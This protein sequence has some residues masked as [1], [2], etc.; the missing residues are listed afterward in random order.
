M[1]EQVLV[2]EREP[3]TRLT[4]GSRGAVAGLALGLVALGLLF[5]TEIAVAVFIWFDSTAYNHCFLV[6]PIAAWLVWERRMTLRHMTPMPIPLVALLALPLGAVWLVAERLGIMEGR[7]LVAVTMAEVLFLAILGRR[8]FLA[9][10]GPLLYLYFLVPFGEFLTPQLQ[11]VTT[12][13]T[14][15]G[16]HLL[17]I[18]AYIDGY[19]IEIPEGVF[20]VAEACAG[21]RFLIASVA[22][23]VLYSIMMYRSPVRRVVFI[24]ASIVIPVIANGIRALGIVVLGHILG[25]AEA[26]ATDHILYGWIFFSIV[27]LLLTLVGLPFRE[28]NRPEPE[29]GPPMIPEPD[30]PRRSVYAGIAVVAAA[31]VGPLVVL[32]L[33]EAAAVPASPRPLDL[34]PSCVMMGA[35]VPLKS[36]PMGHAI[37][38]RMNCGGNVMAVQVEVFSPRST[39]APINAERRRLT[40]P[41]DSEDMTDNALPAEGGEGLEA[42]R[43]LRTA[44]P[45][46]VSAVG[47]W[48]NGA[49]ARPGLAMRLKMAETSLTGTSLAPVIVTVTPVVDWSRVNPKDL[50][51]LEYRLADWLRGHRMIGD[52]VRE[53]AS[54]R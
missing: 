2:A 7:Q 31:A 8:L 18:P 46:F 28:D 13:F 30:A 21:L 45:A 52:E 4:S 39:A 5:H 54:G 44:Q 37:S 51:N 38:Q 50:Q 15:E 20:F 26:A 16:L 32:S 36:S 40:R 10:L 43:I 25:S 53:I 41:P 47:L 22:F 23:G 6:I 9:M 49:P 17:G 14:R 33:S 3:V 27:I 12:W 29:P 11:D 1:S 24:A 35:P 34:S 48:V 42:W 19:I